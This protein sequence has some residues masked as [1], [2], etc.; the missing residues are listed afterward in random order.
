MRAGAV[1]VVVAVLASA[2]HVAGGG[3]H[4]SWLA[5]VLACLAVTAVAATIGARRIGAPT[6]LALLVVAQVG[7]HALTGYLHGL[8]P[9]HDPMMLLAHLG[10]VGV[11]AVVLARGEALLWRLHAWLRPSLVGGPTPAPVVARRV[12]AAAVVPRALPRLL[13]GSLSR[14]GPPVSVA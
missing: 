2:S 3:A 10:G 6:L 12:A 13:T 8:A 9:W 5:V 4:T 14:R 1:G 7:V 11:S